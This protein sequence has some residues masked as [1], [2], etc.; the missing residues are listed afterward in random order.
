M[1][2]PAQDAQLALPTSTYY[3]LRCVVAVASA[4]NVIKEQE[5]LFLRALLAHFK[6]H[7]VVSADQVNQLK[8]D[9]RHH[10]PI[11]ALLPYV[12][13][14]GD[15][16]QLILFAGLLAQADGD[17]APAE[18]AILQKI[19]AHCTPLPGTEEPVPGPAGGHPPS[20][21]AQVH[22]VP[23][24]APVPKLD[25]ASFMQEV[26]DVVKQ[27]FYKQAI[28]TSGVAP[29]TSR[30]AVVDAFVEKSKIVPHA[31]SYDVLAETPKMSRAMRQSLVPEERLLG[32]ARFHYIYTIYSLIISGLL[33][34]AA[35]PV[36]GLVMTLVKM[37]QDYLVNTSPGWLGD[38]NIEVLLR[39]LSSPLWAAVPVVGL[40]ALAL[41]FFLWRVLR[42]L[43]TEIIITDSRIVVKQGIFIIRTFKAD[44]SNLGQVDVNQSLLGG[45]L[46]YGSVHI[47]TQNWSGKGNQMEAE[48][49][50]LPPV[51]E[52]H[53]FSTLVD[54][55]RRMWRTRTV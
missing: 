50:Y 6:R 41:L 38:A 30:A 9:L 40:Y 12:T 31:S 55:A 18:E 32:K 49:I 15:R 53:A 14:R 52:P 54:R 2:L 5:L 29:K 34:S 10:Q 19:R 44:L 1:N 21:P 43:T 4:D 51:A 42:Q 17:M 37:M 48:G 36:A 3:M 45:L 20:A 27:E 13:E 22:I 26:R 47:Y 25:M 33:V 7:M 39:A 8:E 28:A 35:K 46:N 24:I 11:D 16:E 23:A